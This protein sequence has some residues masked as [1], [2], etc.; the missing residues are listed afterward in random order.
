MSALEIGTADFRAPAHFGGR[1][2]GQWLFLV[3]LV[4]VV[5]G[6]ILAVLLQSFDIG[7]PREGFRFGLAHWFEALRNPQLQKALGYTTSIVLTRGVLGFA[8]A[9]PIAWLLARTDM[10]GAHWLEFGFWIAFFMPSLAF[11]QGWVFL[12]DSQRG[13][14]NFWLRQMPL[15]GPALAD[16]LDVFSYWGIIFVHLMSQNVSTLVV[17]LTL[18]FQNIDSSF[19]EAARISGSSKWRTIATIILP[20]S[21]PALAMMVIMA[22]IRGMQSY[23]VEAVLGQ[24]AGITVYS[25]L[26]VQMLSYEPPDIAGG[27]VLSG[28]ILLV[29]LPL[30]LLQRV[31][32]GREQYTTVGSKMRVSRISLGSRTRWIACIGVSFFVALQTLVPFLATLAGSFMVRWGYF[33]IPS[34]WTLDRWRDVLSDDEFISCLKNTLIVGVAS[35]LAAAAICFVIAYIL[36]RAK[37]PAKG[38]LEFVSWLPWAVPGVLLSLGLVTIVLGIAPLRVLYGSLS[39]LVLSVMLFR[40]PLSVHLIKSGLMQVS[41]ELEEASVVCGSTPFMTQ[42]RITI[43]ILSPMLVGVAL[44]TFVGAVNEIS[45]VVLLASTDVRTLSLLSLDYLLGSLPQREAAAVVTTI[46][47]VLCVG[48]ALCARAFGIRLGASGGTGPVSKRFR[49]LD[50]RAAVLATDDSARRR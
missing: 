50:E 43:P 48:V 16:R 33:N 49:S 4:V 22:I 18:A 40:F 2:A 38:M 36:V 1:R 14:V 29:L 13:L 11:I 5:L 23:E 12:I 32:V 27:A 15:L 9:V 31:F 21:R 45:G 30:I 44:M 47:L 24:P 42:M 19:E 17:L 20:L 34:P 6:P 7:A 28:L 41:L 26:V 25:T 3:V 46:M 35:S 37:F 8:I 39:M 10:P